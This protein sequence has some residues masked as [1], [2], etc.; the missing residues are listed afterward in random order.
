MTYVAYRNSRLLVNDS[1]VTGN[2]KE[3]SVNLRRSYASVSS[4]LDDGERFIPGLRSGAMSL[5]GTF[6]SAAGSLYERAAATRTAEDAL[7]V[8]VMPE[9]FTA[10][11]LALFAVTDLDGLDV[12]SATDDAVKVSVSAQADDGVDVGRVLHVHQAE[13]ANGN[14]TAVDDAA[15]TATGGAGALHVTALT[16]LTGL[17][18]KVQHSTDNTVWADLITFTAAT[19][20]TSERKAITGAVN[21]YVRALWTVTGTGSATFAVAFA[22]R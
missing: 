10:G 17:T 14:T 9:G 18:V 5:N 3:W 15:S 21:R 11:K 20:K 12:Q 19:G 22:R 8:T 16:G 4:I 1:H 2:I 7:L 6:D 13:T